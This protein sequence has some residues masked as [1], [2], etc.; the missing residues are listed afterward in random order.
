[1]QLCLFMTALTCLFYGECL[2]KHKEA[3]RILI[4]KILLQASLHFEAKA[5]E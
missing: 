3:A 2:K 1:V 5:G 4:Q